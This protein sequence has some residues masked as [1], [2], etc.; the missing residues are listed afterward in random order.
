MILFVLVGG[1]GIVG[2]LVIVG[3]SGVAGWLLCNFE[4]RHKIKIS[5]IKCYTSC[6][7]TSAVTCKVLLDVNGACEAVKVA[8]EVINFSLA[9]VLVVDGV[10]VISVVGVGD[11][12]LVLV[13]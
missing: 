1:G 2:D 12:D 6:C 5:T 11:I 4:K 9:E 10:D 3:H 7:V 13:D 8:T